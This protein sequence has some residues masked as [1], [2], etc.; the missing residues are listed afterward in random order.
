MSER[1]QLLIDPE[2]RLR[3]MVESVVDY[4]IF[5][6]D[7]DGRVT[8][9]NA[10]AQRILGYAADEIVG[11][12]FSRFYAAPEK[13]SGK[14]A[15]ELQAAAAQGRFE[16]EAWRVRRDGSNFWASVVVTA[17]RDDTGALLGFAK[18]VRDL[19]ERNR[20]EAELVRAKV[21]AE[22]ASEAKSQ[23]LANMS[24]ELR[25]P[26]NSLLILARLLADNNGGN[27]TPK[28]VQFARTIYASGMDLLALINDLLDLAKIESGAIRSLDLAP[29][30]L[31]EL[32]AELEDAF[33]QLAQDKGLAFAVRVDPAVPDTI[34]TDLPRLKQVLKNLL[35]NALK[36]T[37]AGSVTLEVVP[38][39]SG[40]SAEHALLNQ[41]SSVVAFS[42]IDTGIGIPAD[43][44]RIIFEAFQ[45]ADGSTSRH[46]GG[47]G[48]G[49]SISRE[50]TRLLG[51]EIRVA[52]EPG[53]GS[54]FT[55]FLPAS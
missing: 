46:Y 25:T 55:L 32:R 11:E 37:K 50:L 12:H 1:K 29:A 39:S 2:Q 48:L 47:T 35:A 14:P 9:W 16:E 8:S 40:W 43:K 45:Q 49:L 5:M 24:H 4:A 3:L 28:Q 38:A 19:T 22:K 41:A 15:L 21:S 31:D 13:D 52:S 33:H 7:G 10:G 27:L 17:V 18:V 6:L 36:F 34:R 54:R 20:V 53:K 23:F 26:L 44:Q 51:G 30:R 42:V